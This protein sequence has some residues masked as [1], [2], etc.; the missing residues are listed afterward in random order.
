MIRPNL[1]YCNGCHACY[2]ICPKHCIEM[3]YNFEGFLY[4]EVDSEI[5]VD[6]GLCEM[7]CPLLS[8]NT[9]KRH[10]DT[11]AAINKNDKIRQDSSSGGVFYLL[12]DYVLE[13]DGVVFGAAF[14]DNFNVR[15]IC[16]RNKNELYKLQKSKYVQSTIGDSYIKAKTELENGKLVLFTGTPCQISGLLSFLNKK[17]SNLITQ[18]IICHGVPSPLLWRKYL[19]SALSSKPKEIDFRNKSKGWLNYSFVIKCS[20]LII[21]FPF[22]KNPYMQM[23]LQNISLRESCYN[24]KFKSIERASDIT[25]ADFWGA[26]NILPKMFDDKGTSLVLINSQKGQLYFN[27]IKDSLIYLTVSTEEALKYNPSAVKSVA[28]HYK[29]DVYLQNIS[30]KDFDYLYKNCFIPN[31]LEVI[32]KRVVLIFN[33]IQQLFRKNK[34]QF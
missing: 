26:Q 27:L 22:N 9:E 25:L 24:C 29:R 32:K 18:D 28:P 3:K 31:K 30:N 14:D 33:Y 13:N 23:F 10:I 34:N 4:P 21:D 17:Y 19:K 6:C 5:C 20:D 8:D 12:A 16:I 2:S 15:H 7:A 11:Y 1:I